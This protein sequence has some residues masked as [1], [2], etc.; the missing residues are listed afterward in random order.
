MYQI[1]QIWSL[2]TPLVTAMM[3]ESPPKDIVDKWEHCARRFGTLYT[4]RYLA[5]K[6]TP[7]MHVFVYHVGF[8]LKKL[9][10]IECFANYDIESWHRINK[11]IKSFATVAF[12]GRSDPTKSTLGRQQLQHQYRTRFAQFDNVNPM[13]ADQNQAK[14]KRGEDED[15]NL[16][17]KKKRATK[18]SPN[19]TERQLNAEEFRNPL[20][21]SV[22]NEPPDDL[23]PD[24]ES[25]VDVAPEAEEQT[26]AEPTVEITLIQVRNN[27][28]QLYNM[29]PCPNDN[30]ESETNPSSPITS[31]NN[32]NNTT[33]KNSASIVT[34][35][36]I[37]EMLTVIRNFLVENDG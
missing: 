20:F 1:E 33:T 22:L 23:T 17:P 35:K 8:F 6:T 24:Q 7:Y 16:R 14:R 37:V 12:G 5:E 10:N 26:H 9:G 21:E 32:T 31:E 25:N 13:E 18:Q 36:D 11:R 29:M 15:Q 30:N 3:S 27:I 2:Y 34:T 4:A 19:W 28:V